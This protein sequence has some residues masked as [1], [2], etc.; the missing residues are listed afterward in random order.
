MSSSHKKATVK[1]V[2]HKNNDS[3]VKQDPNDCATKEELKKALRKTK[4]FKR[5]QR[6]KKVKENA[7]DT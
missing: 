1:P 2:E 6:R 7:L 3:V 4:N 5:D